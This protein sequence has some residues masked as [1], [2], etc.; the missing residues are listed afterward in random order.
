MCRG[1][2]FL[3]DEKDSVSEYM[4][5][6]LT[7]FRAFVEEREEED[8][9]MLLQLPR[10]QAIEFAHSVN[11]FKAALG[12]FLASESRNGVSNRVLGL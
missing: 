4:S 1:I 10:P 3:L 5:V 6:G 7:R 2:I 12:Q 11:H 9:R 8:K